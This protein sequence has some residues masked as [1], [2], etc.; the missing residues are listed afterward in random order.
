MAS[1]VK[2]T[3]PDI[4]ACTDLL[5]GYATKG[6]FNGF[7]VEKETL[8]QAR[9]QLHWHFNRL[10][11]V[12]INLMTGKIQMPVVFPN[13]KSRSRMDKDF[14]AFIAERCSPVQL[15][16]RRFNREQIKVVN[17]SSNLSLEMVLTEKLSAQTM[18]RFIGLIHEV[19]KIFLKNGQHDTYV[20]EQ[21][22]IDADSFW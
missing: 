5:A 18:M 4:T 13:V 14:R 16:H 6:F 11:Q 17:R 22:Q 3:N 2:K 19:F 15:E 20:S 8:K 12:D 10:Y 7:S 9:Y 1:T 21:Y